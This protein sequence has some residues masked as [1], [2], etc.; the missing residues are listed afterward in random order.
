M[1]SKEQEAY[2]SDA[3]STKSESDDDYD[4][5]DS[6]VSNMPCSTQPVYPCMDTPV[7][8]LHVHAHTHQQVEE[9]VAPVL[10]KGRRQTVMAAAVT[11]DED[12]EAPFYSKTEEETMNLKNS[13]S[14]NILFSEVSE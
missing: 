6:K 13:V 14:T 3:S 7:G 8:N 10:K 4:K 11:V 9:V 12:W 5:E 2:D 1:A